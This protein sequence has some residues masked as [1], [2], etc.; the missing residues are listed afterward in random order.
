VSRIDN[1]VTT[2]LLCGCR[3]KLRIKPLRPSARFGCRSNQGHSYNQLWAS[4]E[5]NGRTF[6]NPLVPASV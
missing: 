4:Y 3:I 5:D 2:V 1:T 6:E